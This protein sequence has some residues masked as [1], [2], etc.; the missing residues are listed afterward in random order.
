MRRGLLDEERNDS[1]ESDKHYDEDGEIGGFR[2]TLGAHK[3]LRTG[4]ACL[5]R[6]AQH[7]KVAGSAPSLGVVVLPRF[8]LQTAL[9]SKT[10]QEV[11][12]VR[13]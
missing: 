2:G 8:S 9:C 11:E 5:T 13:T 6:A 7:S 12:R 4:V 1:N 10:G 3:L